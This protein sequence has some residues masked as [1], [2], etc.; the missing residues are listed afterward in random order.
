MCH[1]SASMQI[2][3][4]SSDSLYANLTMP[5]ANV[6]HCVGD[7]PV[8][9]NMADSSLLVRAIK[10]TTMCSKNG[11]GM[12]EL[13]RMPDHCGEQ[14]RPPCLTEAQIKLVSDWV[15]AGAKM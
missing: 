6:P 14:G 7:K 10:G 4:T 11:G 2:D 8:V 9:A 5:L 15:N 12:E 1:D 3:L 13:A